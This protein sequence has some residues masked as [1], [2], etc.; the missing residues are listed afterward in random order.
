[1]SRDQRLAL[2]AR[3]RVIHIV[4]AAC[5]A[6][7]IENWLEMGSPMEYRRQLETNLPI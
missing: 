3:L 4:D 5:R 1:M 2:D 6:E 7:P